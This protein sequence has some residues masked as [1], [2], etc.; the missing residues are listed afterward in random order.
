MLI[1]PNSGEPGLSLEFVEGALTLAGML[2]AFGLPRTCDRQFRA[3]EKSFA[4]VARRRGLSVLIVGLSVILLRLALLPLLPIPLPFIP[5]DFSFLLSADTFLHGRLTNPTPAMWTHFETIHITMQPTYASMYFPAVGLLLALSKIVFGHPWFGI[6]AVTALMC[7]AI[8]WMLQEWVPPQWALLGGLLAVVHLGLFSYWVNSYSGGGS[9]AGLGGAL[10][11]GALPRILRKVHFRHLLVMAM[12]VV[13]VGFTRPY[14][15]TLL[16]LPVAV[17][18]GIWLLRGENVPSRGSLMKMAAIP[19]VLIVGAVGWLGY[20]D[21]R[22]FGKATTLPYTVDRAT[23]A[24]APYFIW[25]MPR[26]EPQY[27]QASMR[28]FYEFENQ[29]YT[30]P[31]SLWGLLNSPLRSVVFELHFI[32]G[33]ALLPML[34][35]LPAALR[36]RRMRLLAVVFGVLI[37][38]II[39]EVYL[40]PHYLAPFTAMFTC[41]GIQSMRHCRVW[42]IQITPAGQAVV[43]ATLLVCAVMV[44]LRPFNRLL[45]MPVQMRPP[46]NWNFVWYGPDHFGTERAAVQQ[47]LESIPGKQLAIVHYESTHWS[48]DQWVYNG[49]DIDGQRVI[50]ASDMGSI[51]NSKLMDYYKDRT[52]WLIQPDLSPVSVTPYRRTETADAERYNAVPA[53]HPPA[54]ETTDRAPR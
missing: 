26:P 27:R 11:L 34:L 17:R 45:G 16:C 36:D 15:G 3:L 18:L 42:H 31:H 52:A 50:W 48:L 9:I 33:V 10:I 4:V 43:R 47:Q 13:L 20:Y 8:C 1:Q 14:E 12:G 21:Y 46:S 19:L 35:F 2:L 22:N 54:Q 49:A 40:I 29:G 38:G 32:C 5:D 39:P 28:Q 51:Q 23:Y 53:S 44:A 7:A 25:Q 37:V 24:I 41:L 6:L 30:P